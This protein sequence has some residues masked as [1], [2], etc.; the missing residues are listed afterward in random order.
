MVGESNKDQSACKCN[1]GYSA[2]GK[3]CKPLPC[4]A[5]TGRAQ[6]R[7]RHWSRGRLGWRVGGS[8]GHVAVTGAPQ[9]GRSTFL[10]TLA[11]SLALTHT[12][13][14]VSIYGMDLTGGGLSRLEHFPHVGGIATR[15]QLRYVPDFAAKTLPTLLANVVRWGCERADGGTALHEASARDLSFELAEPAFASDSTDEASQDDHEAT[16]SGSPQPSLLLCLRRRGDGPP[17]AEELRPVRR[18][19]AARH[20]D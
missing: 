16:E 7:R 14:E 15:G 19:T 2:S 1:E 17:V 9:S 6:G 12:P 4:P 13:R 10:R 8:G 5:R 3:E 20:G 11:A 18:G